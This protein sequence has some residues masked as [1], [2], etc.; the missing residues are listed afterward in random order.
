[1]VSWQ[2]VDEGPSLT[3]HV[4][5]TQVGASELAQ[6]CESRLRHLS[7]LSD[8][9]AR[10]LRLTKGD[11]AGAD[12]IELRWDDMDT[13][14]PKGVS[15]LVDAVSMPGA[16]PTVQ[17]LVIEGGGGTE[18]LGGERLSSRLFEALALPGILPSLTQLRLTKVKLSEGGAQT[19][20]N[21]F[22]SS[23]PLQQLEGLWLVGMGDLGDAGATAL[24]GNG[25]PTPQPR[26]APACG[27]SIWRM[28]AWAPKPP[29]RC[30][31]RSVMWTPSRLLRPCTSR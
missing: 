4:S 31:R 6:M 3:A 7:S 29:L 5:Q 11:V 18:W 22:H 2:T 14:G 23:G 16:F 30:V 17:Q 25:A 1:M 8:T 27:R 15:L 19:L 12:K 24:S 26:P 28:W 9:A 10:L 20:A 13:M 21:A